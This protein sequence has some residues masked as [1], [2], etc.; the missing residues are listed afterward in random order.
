MLEG[1]DSPGA[2]TGGVPQVFTSSSVTQ[3]INKSVR[4][5]CDIPQS[6]PPEVTWTDL[7]FNVDPNPCIIFQSVNNS[8]LLVNESHPHATFFEVGRALGGWSFG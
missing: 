7:V 5:P 6:D 8:E 1:Q 3:I 2:P 4:L